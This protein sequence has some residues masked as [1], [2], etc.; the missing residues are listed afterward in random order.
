MPFGF[1]IIW[2]TNWAPLR[3]RPQSLP[4]YLL[5]VFL[6]LVWLWK[7]TAIKYQ[8]GSYYVGSTWFLG[9]SVLRSSLATWDAG[10]ILLI[11]EQ[12]AISLILHNLLKMFQG[13]KG[14]GRGSPKLIEFGWWSG[15]VNCL[16]LFNP[17][18][19]LEDREWSE[20]WD[21][22]HLVHPCMPRV[23][24]KAM[25]LGE[26]YFVGVCGMKK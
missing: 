23:Q 26:S 8:I 14:R 6:T 12:R 25:H 7:P 16:A 11:T 21:W 5:P 24:H 9:L 20:D 13:R 2:F 15:Q 10:R 3:P 1:N 4:P 22:A 17:L 19:A 18:S